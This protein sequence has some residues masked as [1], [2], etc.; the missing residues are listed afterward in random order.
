M[1]ELTQETKEIFYERLL[2]EGKSTE[3]VRKY[4]RDLSKLAE[5]LEGEMLTQNKLEAYKIWLV[6]EKNYKTR[7]ANSFLSCANHFCKAMGQSF[8]VPAYKVKKTEQMTDSSL[9]SIEEYQKLAKAAVKSKDSMMALVMQI[10]SMTD[11]RVTE[12]FWITVESL[13]TGIVELVRGGETIK[14]LLP[15]GIVSD[16]KQYVKQKGYQSGIVFRTNRGN[17]VDRFQ[18]WKKLKGL[19]ADAGVEESKVSFQN[20]KRP[21]G[22]VY[23]PLKIEK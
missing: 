3:T 18:L 12:L 23:Y 22:K 4:Q 13:N 14:I 21:L 1:I 16:L 17:P 11:I 20:L 10:L 2:Q 15:V 19:C 5:F 6:K 7:S 9:L 8:F